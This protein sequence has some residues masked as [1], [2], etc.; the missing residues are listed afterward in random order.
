MIQDLHRGTNEGRP[1]NQAPTPHPPLRNTMTWPRGAVLACHLSSIP[2]K[3]IRCKSALSHPLE[4]AGS[5]GEERQQSGEEVKDQP[6]EF[7]RGALLLRCL[8]AYGDHALKKV[9]VG[10]CMSCVFI[11]QSRRVV[12][13][14]RANHSASPARFSQ[15]RYSA[16][17]WTMPMTALTTGL[18]SSMVVQVPT[19]D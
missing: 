14:G 9:E 18:L 8:P 12:A 13:A 4:D 19:V 5:T 10:S 3:I 16:Q 2:R 17:R 7:D 6:A 15:A 1:G 11:S